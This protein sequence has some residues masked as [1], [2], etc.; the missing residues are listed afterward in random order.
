LKYNAQPIGEVGL[1]A[2]LAG[3]FKVKTILVTG[4][5]AVIEEAKNYLPGIEN[6]VVKKMV[7]NKAE[8]Y[9]P[10]ETYQKLEETACKVIKNIEQITPYTLEPPIEVD[11][12]YDELDLVDYMAQFPGYEKVGERTARYYAKDELEAFK[13]F[14][15]CSIIMDLSRVNIFRQMISKLAKEGVEID[16]IR[17]VQKEAIEESEQRKLNI[18]LNKDEE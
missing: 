3:Y 4:D 18:Q 16:L 2:W 5:Y 13:A 6:V 15:A 9:D 11:I 14:T 7:N 10:E 17:K 8:C 1:A 12:L